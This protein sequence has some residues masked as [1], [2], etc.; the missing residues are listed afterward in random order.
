MI[1]NATAAKQI[2]YLMIDLK[3]QMMDSLV[4]VKESCSPEEYRAY[5]AAVG[6][7]VSSILDNVLEPLYSAN[8]A[9]TPPGWED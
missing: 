5:H 3:D 6:R 8:P 2:S 9:L 7:I 1:T 4:V